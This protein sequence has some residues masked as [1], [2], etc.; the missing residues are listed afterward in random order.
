M[1]SAVK[2][3]QAVPRV[4]DSVAPAPG[5]TRIDN[6]IIDRL[7]SIGA[8]A[9]LVYTALARHANG[10]RVCWPTIQRL[11]AVTGLRRRAVQVA[12]RRLAEL[13]EITRPKARGHNAPTYQLRGARSCA[14]EGQGAHVHAP[15]GARSCAKGRTYV[16]EGAHVAAPK[17]EPS[18][19]PIINT[20]KQEA[21]HDDDGEGIFSD[22]TEAS[23]I[24]LG[25]CNSLGRQP[26]TDEPT[27]R[28]LLRVA[29]VSL[30]TITDSAWLADSVA[31][32]KERKA[33]KPW[34]YFRSCL[35]SGAE[36]RGFAL[37]KLLV[38]IDVPAHLLVKSKPAPQGVGAAASVPAAIGDVA[39]VQG[40]GEELPM[41][42]LR[43]LPPAMSPAEVETRRRELLDALDNVAGRAAG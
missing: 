26:P 40:N 24:A 33:N 4:D 39:A 23:R 31:A 17:Q 36:A 14:P 2:D 28:L 9:W 10:D 12:L 20:I 11:A 42:P 8:A 29:V 7:P 34:A 13:G 15:G 3:N 41:D 38:K 30:T 21:G 16:R 18:T 27:R 1:Y 25:I 19:R 32:T 22:W 6:S 5:W 37:E 43:V 35:K